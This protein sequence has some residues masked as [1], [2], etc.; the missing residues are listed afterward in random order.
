MARVG[1]VRRA[2]P[3]AGTM[4]N[5]FS[6]GKDPKQAPFLKQGWMEKKG[7]INTAWKVRFF[8]LKPENAYRD[9][10]KTLCYYK[11]EDSA[12]MNKNG[13]TIEIDISC[14]VSKAPAPDGQHP[15]CMHIST[16]TRTYELAVPSAQELS[17]WVELLSAPPADDDLD[18]DKER[19]E[20]ISS[21]MSFTTSGPLVEV[22]SGWM[23]KKGQ[24][25]FGSKMQK[26]YF[27]LYDNKELHYFEGASMESIQRK[28][29]IKMSDAVSLERLK[30]GD[31]KDFSFCI[32]EKGRDWIL[33]PSSLSA[34]E[35][36]ES[37]LRPMIR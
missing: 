30:P 15:H 4:R 34:W 14:T 8:A 27:V 11:D 29:R 35:E 7:E 37:K 17:E 36:W 10:P 20:S 25:M 32:K 19:S 6:D 26:R 31:K 5:P 16:P 3:M 22:Y 1:E 24:G 12:R 13:S 21:M 23:R 2:G 9:I 33:D 18:G 28:G